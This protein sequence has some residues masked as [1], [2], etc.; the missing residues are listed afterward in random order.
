M[1]FECDH[2]RVSEMVFDTMAGK[3]RDDE[4]GKYTTT[5][6]DSDFL[7]AINNLDGMASTS[8]VAEK[9]GCTHRTAY[10]RLNSLEE[11]KKVTTRRIGNSIMWM[12]SDE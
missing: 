12:L 8:D 4:S 9:V 7:D 6:S 11:K 5:Y 3:D 2:L 10:S 1:A